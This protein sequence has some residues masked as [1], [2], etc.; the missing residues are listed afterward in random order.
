M[1]AESGAKE[2]GARSRW[3]TFRFIVLAMALVGA[4]S[5]SV[6]AWYVTTDGF[7][8]RVRGRLVAELEKITGGRVELGSIHV[9]PLELRV[10]VRDLTIHGREAS[11]EIPYAH[12]DSLSAQIKII[13]VLGAEFGFHSVDLDHP[14]IHVIVYPDGSTNQPA[15]KIQNKPGESPVEPL[16]ALSISR[17]SVRQGTLFWNDEVI[18]LDFV[19][20][21]V[22]ADMNY[23][24]L[25]GRYEGN[26]RLGKVNCK[27]E[28]YRPFSA[29]LAASFSVGR[30]DIAVQSLNVTSG[31][32]R[33]EAHG[34]VGNFLSP[35]GDATYELTVD[36][37]E[38]G[39]ILRD[40][41]LRG[42]SIRL[43]GSGEW[44]QTALYVAGKFAARDFAWRDQ[45]ADI[46]SIALSG[47]YSVNR[48]QIAL[49]QLQGKVLGGSLTGEAEV[50]N[51][52][53]PPAPTAA[54]IKAAPEQVASI[55]LRTRDLAVDQV[56]AAISKRLLSLDRLHLSGTANATVEMRWKGSLRNAEYQVSS[57]IVPPAHLA[58]GQV[59]L[60]AH[61]DG[62]YRARSRELEVSNFSVTT[63]ASHI[64]AYGS[65][66][67]VASLKLTASTTDLRELQPLIV[68][69]HGPDA[70]PVILHGRAAF[71]GTA[72]GNLDQAVLAGNLTAGD[73]DIE[74]PASAHLAQ[75]H[76]HWDSLT[77]ALRVSQRGIALRGGEL[78]HDD[79]TVDFDAQARFDNGELTG[80]SPFKAHVQIQKADV[81]EI[82]ALAGKD[83]AASGSV[84]LTVSAAGTIGAPEGEGNLD[85]SHAVFRGS[86]MDRLRSQFTFGGSQL[87]LQQ[88][89]IA[90]AGARITGGA[91]YSWAT[92]AVSAD[93]KGSNF[94]LKRIPQLQDARVVV[95]GHMDF[96]AHLSGTTE[97]PDVDATLHLSDLTLDGQPIGRFNLETKTRGAEMTIS[98][99]SEF[100]RETLNL[101]GNVHMRGDFPAHINATFGDFDVQPF[102]TRYLAGHVLGASP[103]SGSAVIEGDLRRPRD[104]TVTANLGEFQVNVERIKLHNDGPLRFS[105]VDQTLKIDQCRLVSEG[106]DVSASGTVQLT[107]DQAL[108]LHAEGQLNLQLLSTYDSDF[109]SSGQLQ[110]NVSIS[111]TFANPALQGRLQI[112]NGSIAYIDLPSALSN[113]NGAI[114]FNR[115]RAE[116]ETL[117]AYTGGGLISFRGFAASYNRQ[118]NFDLGVTGQDVRL[119]YPPGVS[120][121]ATM[122]LKF[123]GSSSSSLLSGDITINKLGMTQGFD[124]GAYLARQSQAASLPQTNPLLNRIRMDV[125]IVT[126]PELQMQT[127]V[128][129]LSG[130]ADLHLRGTAAKP[131]LLGRADVIEG[132]AY[133]NGTKYRMERGDVTFTSPV[134][135]TPVLDMQATTRIRDY[136]ITLNVNG[137]VDKL[138]ITYRSEPPLPTADIIA[139]LAFGQTEE[140][141]AQLQQSN[142]SAFA[143]GAS[144]A[145]LGEALNA[146]LGNRVQR[147]FGV[148]RIKIDPQGL[149][150]ET[151]TTQSG[152]AVTIEQQ[153]K[154]NLTVTYTTSVNQASQQVIQV[155]YNL[156][157]NISIVALRD[158]N[159]VVSIVTKIRRRKQ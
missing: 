80:A 10:E 4:I 154:N 43:A 148:S 15:L 123:A 157:R 57:E 49:S 105:I 133:F 152:P 88:I 140:E 115:N 141:S 24:L 108:D 129:R 2:A 59:P 53:T 139:L 86:S 7:H 11:S 6:L 84:N 155:E 103:L 149:S 147:L 97:E 12:V 104:L 41:R 83:Y 132:E 126:V 124:F 42:G 150:T 48:A 60:A 82:L 54:K 90:D 135:T 61:A 38:M 25:R 111:G 29:T 120:S 156:T 110:T 76:V 8:S 66:S 116:I 45:Y 55:K 136:D 18:P 64:Q 20:D 31:K 30:N 144:S 107:G 21:E 75:N 71:E 112:S 47:N 56:A 69:L 122:D 130:D 137:Q 22:G 58:P 93:L 142:Q 36:A 74:L 26:L 77:T 159:G 32:S 92:H 13:S 100:L 27:L 151:S 46:G 50:R 121:T 138:N 3:H 17:L 65:L 125:H 37:G 145:L 109:T 14:V 94:A 89:E 81:Q 34:R 96:Q 153:V 1:T 16:F 63:P 119:R 101:D 158:Q 102:L 95:D 9:I 39:A 127:A 113:I 128:V 51:W 114:V 143:S 134:T 70:I 44:S 72:T 52:L 35:S 78:Q 23:S 106:T 28:N 73:F 5:F 85:V 40:L 91:S 98:G 131:V 118:L 117:T 87:A 146:T 19:V 33:L 68:M 99:R 62:T 67:S 79:T